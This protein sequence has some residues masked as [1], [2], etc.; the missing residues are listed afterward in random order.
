MKCRFEGVIFD[1][2]GTIAYTAEDVWRAV[3]YAVELEGHKIDPAFRSVHTNLSKPVRQMYEEIFGGSISDEMFERLCENLDKHYRYIT[4]YPTTYMYEGME[5][6]LQ[7]LRELGIPTGIVTNK[8]E[9]SLRRILD[10][11]G[12]GRYFDFL[13]G[14]DSLGDGY[15]KPQ[16]MA[17]MLENDFPGKSCVY[18][19]DSYSD[20]TSSRANGIPCIGLT[21]GDG[22]PEALRAEDPDWVCDDL[23][24][25]YNI[26]FQKE[27]QIN[28]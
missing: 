14:C 7:K 25:V 5:P 16:L 18:I 11:K 17:H 1:F 27:N 3:D 2:D 20:V 9:F 6:I 15:K 24:E 22:D 8:G 12:W 4:D 10:I 19:G 28:A 21:Y 23:T 13:L 26:L